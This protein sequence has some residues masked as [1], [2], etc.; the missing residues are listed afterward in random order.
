MSD[1]W[2][3]VPVVEV[4]GVEVPV[5]EVP[6]VEV[7]VVEGAKALYKMAPRCHYCIIHSYRPWL[8]VAYFLISLKR[9][10][11]SCHYHLQCRTNV[12]PWNV[13][14]CDSDLLSHITQHSEFCDAVLTN[15]YIWK[16]ISVIKCI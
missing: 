5:V 14:N 7:P 9:T 2:V 3:E 16:W 6:G 1:S 12:A 13:R 15:F 8:S 11:S 4:P 10:R